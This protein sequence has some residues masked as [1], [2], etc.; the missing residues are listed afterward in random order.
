MQLVRQVDV[1]DV[2]LSPG[3]AGV[4]ADA[5]ER[6]PDP[7]AAHSS[8]PGRAGAWTAA[9]CTAAMICS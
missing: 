7:R 5:D 9:D 4:A 8:P 3:D 6:I 1:R 2:A